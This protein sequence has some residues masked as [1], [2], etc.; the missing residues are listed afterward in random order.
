MV[1][2]TA[3]ILDAGGRVFQVARFAVTG[4]LERRIECQG[5]ITQLGEFAGVKAGCLLFATADGVR[6]DDGRVA[7]LR[8]E[9]RGQVEIGGEF[10]LAVLEGDGLFHGRFPG[11][12]DM[13]H[14]L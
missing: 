1:H 7:L 3:E 8:I 11:G 2:R 6:A 13:T 14:R 4:A 9:V 10:Q 12:L 5:H